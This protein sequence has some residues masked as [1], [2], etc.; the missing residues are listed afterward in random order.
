VT[1]T[2][3]VQQARVS[4]DTLLTLEVNRN[5]TPN[6]LMRGLEEDVERSATTDALLE[7][8]VTT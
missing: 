4:H 2:G 7:P 8:P 1:V 6:V 5:D 3:T